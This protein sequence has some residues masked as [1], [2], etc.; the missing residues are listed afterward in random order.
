MSDSTLSTDAEPAPRHRARFVLLVIAGIVA[1]LA[2]A[3]AMLPTFISWG[4]LDGKVVRTVGAAVHGK[5]TLEGI[6][7][8]WASG[9]GIRGLVIDDTEHGNRIEVSASVEQGLWELFTAGIRG[10]D[11]H[12][13][14]SVHTRRLADGSLALAKLPRPVLTEA[15]SSSGGSSPVHVEVDPSL[16]AGTSINLFLDGITVQVDDP[17]GAVAAA[18]R[19]VKGSLELNA[20]GK[21]GVT[22]AGT[23]QVGQTSGSFELSA[24]AD[25]L[26]DANG[27]IVYERTPATLRAKA[28]GLSFDAGGLA[29]RVA[30]LDVDV[31]SQ[32]LTGAVDAK[33]TVHA[34]VDGGAPTSLEMQLRAARLLDS[35]GKFVFDLGGLSGTVRAEGVPTAPLQRF[36]EGTPVVLARDLGPTV[37]LNASFADATGSGIRIDARSERATL[38]AEGAVDPATRAATLRTVAL[39]ATVDPAL[40]RAAAGIELRAPAR[41]T[42]NATDLLVPPA[43]AD[44]SFPVNALRF[45]AQA[46]V[47]LAG[48]RVPG[49][50]GL[51]DVAVDAI[52]VT[53]GA[54]PLGS[55][56]DIDLTA[57]ASAAASGPS[58]RDPMNLAAELR[59]GGALGW[60]G[61]LR[62]RA[63]PCALLDPWVPASVHLVP[64]RDLGAEIRTVDARVAAGDAPA[65]VLSVESDSLGVRA[66]G[67]VGADGATAISGARVDLR[68]VRPE[69]LAAFGVPVEQAIDASLVVR[70]ATLP[71]RQAFDVGKVALDGELTVNSAGARQMAVARPPAAGGAPAAGAAPAAG[72][73]VP[74]QVRLSGEGAQARRIALAGVRVGIATPAL[75]QEVALQVAA[76]VDD[77]PVQAQLSAKGLLRA[78]AN[79]ALALDLEGARMQA[80][81]TVSEITAQRVGR[82]V[83]ALAAI[84]PQV[85]DGR[86]S[87]AAG[88]EGSLLDGTA[89]LALDS[90][91]RTPT[92]AQARLTA[93][94]ARESIEASGTVSVVATSALVAA[95]APG[96]TIALAAPA[97]VELAIAPIT[98]QR[99]GPWAVEPPKQAQ[100][101]ASLAKLHLMKV[102][103]LVGEP[104]LEGT[105]LDA[106]VALA[107]GTAI[108]TTLSTAIASARAG[109]QP[110]PVAKLAL[111]GGWSAGDAR[112]APRWDADMQVSDLQGAALATL[113]DLGDAGGEIGAGGSAKVKVRSDAPGAIAFD[114]DSTIPRLRAVLRGDLTNE[115][116]TLRDS[117][118]ALSLP[119]P[120][121]VAYLNGQAARAAKAADPN[122][123]APRPWKSAGPLEV[124]AEIPNLRMDVVPTRAP[125]STGEPAPAAPDAPVPAAAAPSFQLPA[126]FAA[127]ARIGVKPIQLVPTEG[128][129]I[130][131]EA[132]TLVADAPGLGKPASLQIDGGIIGPDGKRAPLTVRATLKDW[133]RED[134]SVDFKRMQVDATAKAESASTGVV[135]ALMGKGNELAEALGPTATLDASIRSTGPGAA[136]AQ[137]SL[138]SK[139]LQIAAPQVEIKDGFAIIV[140]AKPLRAE[141]IPSDPLRERLLEPI[142]PIFKDVRLADEK[143]PIVFEATALRWPFDGDY[144]KCDG[145]FDL[146]VGDVLI[147]RNPSNEVLN[148]LKVFQGQQGKPVE[149]RIDPLKVS[150]ARGQL[151]YSDFNVGIEK[152]GNSWVTRLIF[153]GDVDLTRKPPFARSIA[154]NY[155]LS[156]VARSVINLLPNE[157]GGGSVADALNV[158]SLGATDAVQLRVTLKGPL[159]DVDG[160]PAVM[161]R[162]VKVVF[163][164]RALGG[165]VGGAAKGAAE[166]IGGAIED[167]FGRKKN[168]N[169]KNAK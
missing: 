38:R 51:V 27:R 148:L 160:K 54:A 29:M 114:V 121:V 53:V 44:G 131:I 77:M 4:M 76:R 26:V 111:T 166:A 1:L 115:V 10:L 11:V 105:A 45:Q 119:G 139:Y 59:A 60:H 6:D 169:K 8:S 158:L 109:A 129:P 42:L 103:G 102:P 90:G 93:K 155:P 35:K 141:F 2:I 33:A 13:K 164:A 34:S 47:E 32:D 95:A 62:A 79:G 86:F 87:L 118:L 20:G 108:R 40:L 143:K 147:E 57:H 18:V 125:A 74:F 30:D 75:A 70:S 100:V 12:L 3:V 15:S 83:P 113:V 159:G 151:K 135:G 5:V 153:S 71:P 106:T 145:Q 137:A 124:N 101:R 94:L 138:T 52:G 156:S 85:G 36:L 39:E 112:T 78:G 50:D 163:D 149:G 120:S 96:T 162:K 133:S 122:K 9:M 144:A 107:G 43:A 23:T 48:M 37:S 92:P 21:T 134:G 73:E 98:L 14:G 99:T 56:I 49:P 142:N 168:N 84:A 80:T 123:P 66:T 19:D 61:M 17:A 167:I 28:S 81:A 67:T 7:A 68:R 72:P 128:A 161:Q 65:I 24:S 46:R 55:A 64:S 88:L 31:T 117:S 146:V 157:D 126:G 152:Q 150:V 127:V 69:L 104:V 130:S 22:L 63:I 91:A 132:A 41:V 89:T 110:A 136:M 154:A 165:G 116:L 82:E 16:P 58:A 140:P 97:P 25:K